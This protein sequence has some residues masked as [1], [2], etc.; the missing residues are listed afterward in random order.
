MTEAADWQKDRFWKIDGDGSWWCHNPIL[1][2]QT[3]HRQCG[4]DKADKR[5]LLYN[6]VT[7]LSH[8]RVSRRWDKKVPRNLAGQGISN[9]GQASMCRRG[10]SYRDQPDL[11]SRCYDGLSIISVVCTENLDPGVVMIA[12]SGADAPH[13]KR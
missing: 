6:I 1:V 10:L 4:K 3:N 2:S 5:F 7:F 11:P 13:R 12:R 9:L 8:R